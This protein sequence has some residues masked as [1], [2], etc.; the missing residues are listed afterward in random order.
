[1]TEFGRAPKFD[2]KDGVLHISSS[3]VK[4]RIRFSP[5]PY[6]EEEDHRGRWKESW[7]EF[8]LVAPRSN[9][10]LQMTKETLKAKKEA[11]ESFRRT[12]PQSLCKIAAPFASHQW[13]LLRLIDESPAGREL[14]EANPVLGYALA[15]S[16]ELRST[17]PKAAAFQALSHSHDKQRD[18]CAWLGFPG[19]PA[20][21]RLLKRIRSDAASPSLLRRLR[22][23]LKQD[24][25]K[26]LKLLAH[27]RRINAGVVDFVVLPKLMELTTPKL[28]DEIEDSENEAVFS[29]AGDQV[30]HALQILEQIKS[31]REMRP[32]QSLRQIQNF[33][34]AVDNEYMEH[35]QRLEEERAARTEAAERVERERQ[36]E[37]ARARSAPKRERL[38]P[39]KC[40]WPPPPIPGTDSIMPITSYAMLC[41]ESSEQNNCIRSYWRSVVGENGRTYVYRLIRPVR[42]TFIIVK[43]AGDT[44][45]LSQIKAKNNRKVSTKTRRIVEKW[46][47]SYSLSAALP[48]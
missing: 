42:A 46:L 1:M 45:Y 26:V 30:L 3:L 12:I 11:F 22:S 13:M 2:C 17:T 21:V 19:T 39:H 44:W 33:V 10:R 6:A 5:K 48:F 31:R 4:M 27:R 7:P 36:A 24:G 34:E 40:V 20:M 38:N 32:F 14:T 35:Q 41:E 16:Y 47:Y 9:G 23:A 25:E 18:L 8:R 28:L 37:R 43:R 15:N 29:L